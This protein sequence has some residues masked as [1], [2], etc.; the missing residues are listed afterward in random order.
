MR[1]E[2]RSAASRY[3]TRSFVPTLAKSTRSSSSGSM[4]TADGTSIIMPWAMVSPTGCPASNTCRW[5]SSKTS[6]AASRS[7]TLASMG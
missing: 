1:S 3:W 7:A 2:L 5:A 4:G 6:S